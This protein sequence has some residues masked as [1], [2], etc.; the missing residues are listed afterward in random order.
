VNAETKVKAGNP[1]LKIWDAVS[2]TDPRHTKKVNQRGGF[3]AI[4]AHYQVMQAT[5]QFGPIGIG[6]GYSNGE[7][8][9]HDSLVIV[10]VTLWHGKRDN[11]FGP[12]Y[13]GAEWRNGTRL[14][15]DAAKKAATDG[16]TKALSQLG[17]NAD[18]FLGR[19][20]DNKYVEELR[21]EFAA[22]DTPTTGE[23][24]PN[25]R[26]KLDG[27]YTCPTQLRTAAKEFVRT[28]E[29]MGDFSEFLAW[30]ATADFKEFCT[31]LERDMPD[32]WSGGETVPAEF[33]P[34]EIRIAQKKRDLEQIDSLPRTQS[35]LEAG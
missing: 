19:F 25:K 31:Q 14:D 8:I 16:L 22:N 21:K 17:F 2:I 6:W 3:T 1:N 23:T 24:P 32:W 18:V 27:P 4:S 35:V 15:S 10:P 28:L 12:V 11:T 9:F 33:V 34:L 29:S 7:P 26:V 13:G 30:E 5:A 20:D